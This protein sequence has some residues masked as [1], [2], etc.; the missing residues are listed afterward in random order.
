MAHYYYSDGKGNISSEKMEVKKL[1][2]TRVDKKE[3]C[4]T[5]AFK[6]AGIKSKVKWVQQLESD[7][8]FLPF[9]PRNASKGTVVTWSRKQN[10][11]SV[12][13]EI[14]EDG[15]IINHPAIIDFHLGVI[16]DDNCI[17]VSDCT[18]KVIPNAVPCIRIR[19][20]EEVRYPDYIL[21]QK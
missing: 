20:F 7:F 18:R 11:I 10:E 9:D 21:K 6:R 17:L 12:P 2:R 15:T 16:E 8:E 19:S 14:L 3:T 4:L 13:S 1:H 5:Y